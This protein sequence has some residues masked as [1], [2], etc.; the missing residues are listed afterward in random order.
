M[1]QRLV[2]TYADISTNE[3]C[4]I[5]GSLETLEFAARS[6]NARELLEMES[7]EN[8]EVKVAKT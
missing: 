1:I 3:V 5:F 8:I 2:E 7:S 6:T 4:G